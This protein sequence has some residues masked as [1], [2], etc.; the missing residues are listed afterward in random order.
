MARRWGISPLS[1]LNK[2]PSDR[3]LLLGIYRRA[4]EAE[5]ERKRRLIDGLRGQMT[6]PDP[7]WFGED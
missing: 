1:I 6:L 3:M 7:A 2:S 5:A 4:I